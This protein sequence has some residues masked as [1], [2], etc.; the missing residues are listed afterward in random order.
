MVPHIQSSIKHTHIHT[1]TSL[2]C[3]H[4]L[5]RAAPRSFFMCIPG[6]VVTVLETFLLSKHNRVLTLPTITMRLCVCVADGTHVW[7]VVAGWLEPEVGGGL[8]LGQS[9]EGGGALKTA[10]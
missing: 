4:L 1:H 7:S 9:G 10:T 3:E 6:L 8:H 5:Q 2:V